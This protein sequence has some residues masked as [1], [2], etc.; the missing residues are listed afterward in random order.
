[1]IAAGRIAR[2]RRAGAWL[3]G[4]ILLAVA[5]PWMSRGYAARYVREQLDLAAVA[6]C[7]E[8]DPGRGG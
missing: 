4:I 3:L 1:M 6:V 5:L 8:V 2:A 7:A